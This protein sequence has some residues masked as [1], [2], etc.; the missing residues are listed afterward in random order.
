MRERIRA[1]AAARRKAR[2]RRGD[3]GRRQGRREDKGGGS[4][5]GVTLIRLK[6]SR[7]AVVIVNSRVNAMRMHL[8]C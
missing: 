4:L 3:K 8:G 7:S 5:F 1:G 2:L 6:D